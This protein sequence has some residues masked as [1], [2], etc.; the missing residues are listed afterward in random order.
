[1]DTVGKVTDFTHT[2]Q[3]RSQTLS[4]TEAEENP[5]PIVLLIALLSRGAG[6]PG[7]R[8]DGDTPVCGM[9]RF[10]RIIDPE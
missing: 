3:L 5:H 10:L 1:V 6:K 9:N 4:M 7:S 8:G 2:S